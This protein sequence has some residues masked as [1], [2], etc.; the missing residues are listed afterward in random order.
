MHFA[1][2]AQINVKAG[3]GGN[4]S[5]SFRRE[6]YVAKGGPD[7]GNGGDGGSIVMQ[8]DSNLN[9]LVNFVS[10]KHYKATHG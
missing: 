9:T 10:K 1:D 6:K 7:G 4:G 8:A 5:M 2:E 3:N